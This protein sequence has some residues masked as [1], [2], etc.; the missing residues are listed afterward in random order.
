MENYQDILP[1][2]TPFTANIKDSASTDM[3]DITLILTWV[4]DSASLISQ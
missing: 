1:W 3:D 4:L 2:D